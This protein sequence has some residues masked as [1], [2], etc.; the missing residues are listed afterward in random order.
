MY[1]TPVEV[2]RLTRLLEG[3]DDAVITP[4]I[5]KAQARIDAY[6]AQRYAAP[7]SEPIPAIIRSIAADLSASFYLDEQTTERFKDQTTYAEVLFKRGQTD[8]ERVVEDGLIDKLPGV[9]LANRASPNYIRPGLATT[10]PKLSP[11]EEVLKRW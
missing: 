4:F 6:L 3:V 11:M 5:E 7:L 1:C 10:T 2:T 9:I 8:L